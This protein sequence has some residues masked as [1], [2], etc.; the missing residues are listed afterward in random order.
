M[1]F[2][3]CYNGST[4]RTARHPIFLLRGGSDF[5]LPSW[6]WSHA[7]PEYITRLETWAGHVVGDAV[8]PIAE[9]IA[10]EGAN[11]AGTPQVVGLVGS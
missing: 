11:R 4:A 1:K 9:P 2:S 5:L 6:F 3:N 10:E 7:L 8:M